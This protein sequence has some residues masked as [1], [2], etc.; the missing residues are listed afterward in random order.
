MGNEQIRTLGFLL[1]IL[2]QVDHH[3]CLYGHVQG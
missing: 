1:D 2:H 3:L